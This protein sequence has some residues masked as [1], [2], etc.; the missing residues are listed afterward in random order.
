MGTT[1]HV[2]VRH[3]TDADLDRAQ[4]RIAELE[5]T[6]SRF[7]PA[8]ELSRLNANAGKPCVVSKETRDVVARAVEAWHDTDGLYDPT[9]LPA[10]EAAGY[11]RSFTPDLPAPTSRPRPSPGCA[12]ITVGATTVTLPPHVR[13]DLGGIG[14]GYAADLVATELG[15]ECCVNIGGDIRVVGP[16]WVVALEHDDDTTITLDGNAVATTTNAKR[17][18]ADGT[19]HHL[20][21]P[22][23][24]A[25]ADT[26]YETTTVSVTVTAPEAWQAEAHAKAAFLRP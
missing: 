6:W 25:P 14:K 18:W 8:S 2:I 17:R 11:T 20:I 16:D 26:G 4:A 1:A 21:D 13:L 12:D 5:R 7:L 19:R 15:A 10:L 23:T 22:R 9:V 24:G 3:G